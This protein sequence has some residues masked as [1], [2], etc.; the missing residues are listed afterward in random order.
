MLGEQKPLRERKQQQQQSHYRTPTDV[1]AAFAHISHCSYAVWRVNAIPTPMRTPMAMAKAVA[2]AMS[3]EVATS[4][5]VA[6]AH[7]HSYIGW[8]FCSVAANV[9]AFYRPAHRNIFY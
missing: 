7:L 9:A 2:V 3:V 4:M 6:N 5:A 8:L 1:G